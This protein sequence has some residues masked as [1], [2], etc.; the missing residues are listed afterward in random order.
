MLLST[1]R[2]RELRRVESS[3]GDALHALFTEPGVRRYLFDDALLTRA[4]TQQHVEAACGYEAWTILCD[5]AVAG[6]VALRPVEGDRELIIAVGER[7]WSR[8]LAFAAAKAAMWHAFEV[9]GLSRLI[10]SVDLPNERSHQLMRRLGF[11]ATGEVPGP[12]HRLRTYTASAQQLGT[13]STTLCPE[14]LPQG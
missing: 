2:S 14:R 1:D 5:G 8:G 3:G 12:K 10:A 13:L 11:A 4:E 7:Y 9:L 6:L